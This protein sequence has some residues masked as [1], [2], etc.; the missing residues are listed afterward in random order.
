MLRGSRLAT[1]SNMLS[2]V[3]ARMN[4]STA[5]HPASVVIRK[6]GYYLDYRRH[7]A[8]RYGQLRPVVE[9][10][11]DLVIVQTDCVECQSHQRQYKFVDVR[12]WF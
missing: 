1:A 2:T 4:P 3:V 11:Y 8:G 7:D 12:D 9:R 10:T 6:D 5:R